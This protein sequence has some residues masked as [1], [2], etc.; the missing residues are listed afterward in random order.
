MTNDELLRVF[1]ALNAIEQE[2]DVKIILAVESGSRAWG[3]PSI[4]SD[5]DVRFVYI[6]RPEVYVSVI[7]KPEIITN[8]QTRA[9]TDLDLF[10]SD[11]RRTLRFLIKWNPS[12]V[13]W[14]YSVPRNIYRANEHFLLSAR[15]AVDPVSIPAMVRAYVGTAKKTLA[16]MSEDPKNKT[17]KKLIY[18]VRPF[19]MAEYLLGTGEMPSGTI[20]SLID[21][22]WN[23]E[24]LSDTGDRIAF[25]LGAM[26]DM[27]DLKSRSTEAHFNGFSSI[28]EW[29]SRTGVRL[30]KMA[31]S[32][33]SAIQHGPERFDRIMRDMVKDCW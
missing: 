21:W 7:E 26:R 14:V 30:Q 23:Q 3:A 15:S 13:E 1:T 27:L 10:G 16:L 25:P 12:V 33:P 8:Q 9:K 6:R 20:V 29:V 31:E 18:V 28:M 4:D 11:I 17:L 19:L 5:F 22:I 2:H 24:I 32:L